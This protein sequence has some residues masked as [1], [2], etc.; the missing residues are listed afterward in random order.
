MPVPP[1]RRL[2][3]TG[4]LAAGV[5]TL[6]GCRVRL[7]D[8]APDIPLVPT[9]EPIPGESVLLA[10]LGALG[11]S[12]AE[13]AAARAD[14]LRD[15][16]AQARVPNDLLTA[17]ATPPRSGETV[18]AYEGS[19]RDCGAGLLPLV[20]RLTATHR[21]VSTEHDELW[22][23]ASTEPW[24]ADEVAADALQATRATIYALDLIAARATDEQVTG[25]VRDASA[26][27]GELAVRQTTAAGEAVRPATLGYDV[28]HELTPQQSRGLGARSF[29]RLL[30][31]YAAGFARLGQDRAAALETT[32]WMVTAEQLS[33][34]QFPLPV[35][36]L[37]GAAPD[38]S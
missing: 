23:E 3:L 1:S 17:A 2:V 29:T 15:A 5:T 38:E 22:S 9:R 7:E 33:R 13:H 6:T 27:L 8:D 21:I 14:L 18:P 19:L 24:S 31:A 11:A 16:L 20:G 25:Q 10:V 34:E 32:Q 12:T 37:Y 35:P 28:P 4:A 36:V 26:G 30:A